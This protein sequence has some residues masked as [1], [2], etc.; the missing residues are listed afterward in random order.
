MKRLGFKAY[1]S[2]LR[3]HI[4]PD[5][6]NGFS[7]TDR[8]EKAKILGAGYYLRKPYVVER[9]GLAVRKELDSQ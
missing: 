1:F 5:I 2:T 6:V 3:N 9:L 7:E 8:V 4:L